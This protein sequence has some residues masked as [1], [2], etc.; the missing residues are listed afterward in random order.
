MPASDAEPHHWR[1]VMSFEGQPVFEYRAD[2]HYECMFGPDTADRAEL[3]DVTD[4]VL[5]FI[6]DVGVLPET[7]DNDLKAVGVTGGFLQ[8]E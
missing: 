3:E 8:G 7:F 1:V 6:D 4:K 5:A 2:M